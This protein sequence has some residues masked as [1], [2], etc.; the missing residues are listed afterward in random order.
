MADLGGAARAG[1]ARRAAA[2]DPAR[3]EL[4]RHGRAAEPPVPHS[5]RIA[6]SHTGSTD[7]QGC[8]GTLASVVAPPTPPA[9]PA[10]RG[11]SHRQRPR[12]HRSCRGILDESQRHRRQILDKQEQSAGGGGGLNAC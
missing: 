11:A 7:V 6:A 5:R 9:P 10:L 4:A 8:S 3:L 1:G 2:V 12:R